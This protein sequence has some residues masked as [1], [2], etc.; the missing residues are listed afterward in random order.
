MSNTCVSFLKAGARDPATAS[1]GAS[2]RPRGRALPAAAGAVP[3]PDR[4]WVCTGQG[5]PGAK[6]N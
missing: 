1:G 2:A 6:Q 3:V 4:G 5:G